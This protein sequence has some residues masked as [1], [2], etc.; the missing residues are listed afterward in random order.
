MEPEENDDQN[1]AHRYNISQ[2]TNGCILNVGVGEFR[3]MNIY[4]VTTSEKL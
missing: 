1:C 2:Y 3:D 4:V